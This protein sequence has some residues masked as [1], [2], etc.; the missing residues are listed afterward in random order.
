M[1]NKNDG[2]GRRWWESLPPP[3]R[4]RVACPQPGSADASP[5]PGPLFTTG[6]LA[7]DLSGLALLFFV[8]AVGNMLFLLVAL[9]LIVG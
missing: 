9:A 3:I 6:E 5:V 2:R 4:T 8:I 1:R 7:R